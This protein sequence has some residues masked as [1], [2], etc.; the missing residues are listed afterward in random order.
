M[1][2]QVMRANTNRLGGRRVV[3]F[4]SRAQGKAKSRSDFDLGVVGDT[5]LPLADFVA[6]EDMLDELPTLYRIDWV[7]LARV[8]ERF[9]SQA[10]QKAEVIHE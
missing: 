1:L 5:P 10:L 2:I 7:D 4:G 3:L 8:S 9:R 6:I